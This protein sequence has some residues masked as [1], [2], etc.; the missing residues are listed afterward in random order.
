MLRLSKSQTYTVPIV[1]RT[2]DI[3]ELLH[4]SDFPLKAREIASITTISN[5]TTYRIL[6]TLLERGYVVQNVD[7]EF[8]IG[9]SANLR[10]LPFAGT[11]SLVPLIE[12]LNGE[13]EP[14]S[15]QIVELL[16][17]VLQ[18]LRRGKSVQRRKKGSEPGDKQLNCL[19]G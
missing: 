19:D 3:V 16:L 17:A 12:S 6:R 14:S 11:N 4:R 1:L 7:G 9:H 5:T 10:A 15:D 18:A 8:I 13:N 2:L